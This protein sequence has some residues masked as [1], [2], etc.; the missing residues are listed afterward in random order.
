MKIGYLTYIIIIKAANL[1]YWIN[2][3]CCNHEVC[4]IQ[5][6]CKNRDKDNSAII[7]DYK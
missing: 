5:N 7:N 2:N 4:N 1:S 3:Y 6:I